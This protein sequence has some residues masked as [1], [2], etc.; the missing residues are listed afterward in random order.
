MITKPTVLVLGAGASNPYGYPT[1]K[2]LKKTIIED[3][4]RNGSKMRDLLINHQ[5]K[6]EKEII[7]FRKAL[8]RSGQASID[9]FL[10]HQP[11]YIEIGKLVITV[12]LAEKENLDDMFA[13]GDWY[14][15]LFRNLDNS[16]EDF[17]KNNLSIITFN[18]DRSIE[19]Y[20]FNA[21]KYS[22][23]KR[24]ED[25][26]RALSA[27]PI[28]HLHGQIGNLPW[29]NDL[30][31]RDY[32]NSDENFKL[33]TSSEGIRIIHE[34]DVEKSDNFNKA[35]ELLKNANQI[36]FLGFG[37]HSENVRRL[38]ILDM[39]TSGKVVTGTCLHMTGREATDTMTRCSD[40]IN[41]N[42]PGSHH[43]SILDFIRENISFL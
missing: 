35:K 17:E 12:A 1:G 19:T 15:H 25:V 40:K 32:G 28:I 34:A 10:E 29:Q 11:H 36:Y 23:G 7:A 22:Y 3:L 6:S 30:S 9:A 43:M 38:G 39:D 5:A 42:E 31:N 16:F 13:R 26:A 33:K 24:E 21:L 8:M 37:Y 41:L 20:L 14:E 18:Y 27:I 4:V 2:N